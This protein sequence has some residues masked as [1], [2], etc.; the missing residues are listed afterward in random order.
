MCLLFG[1]CVGKS[2]ETS[3]DLYALWADVRFSL[4]FS[5][6][7]LFQTFTYWREKKL[8]S[9]RESVCAPNIHSKGGLKLVSRR[10]TFAW[11][12]P[13]KLK[14]GGVVCGWIFSFRKPPKCGKH[15]EIFSID[16][17]IL[18]ISVP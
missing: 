3:Q 6:L 13:T 2:H 16:K 4:D 9:S 8:T 10:I 1:Q 17:N 14:K 5:D 11:L 15:N 18:S 7:P 12:L